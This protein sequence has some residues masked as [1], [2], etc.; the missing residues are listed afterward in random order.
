V[1]TIVAA[2]GPSSSGASVSVGSGVLLEPSVDEES[3]VAGVGE[4]PPGSQAVKRARR[5]T[6]IAGVIRRIFL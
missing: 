5:V 1:M 4:E 6:A 2:S 3:G